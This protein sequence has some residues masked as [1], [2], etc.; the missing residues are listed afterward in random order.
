VGV[1][2]AA[3]LVALRPYH[4]SDSRSLSYALV[5][6]TLNFF[7]YIVAGLLLLRQTL[8]FPSLPGA[9]TIRTLDR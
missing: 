5:L 3:T 1:F 2:E 4:V 9:D 8:A 7:T 6:H